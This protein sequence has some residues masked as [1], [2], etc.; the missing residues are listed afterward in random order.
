MSLVL[1]DWLSPPTHAEFNQNLY[2]SLECDFTL[3]VYHEDLANSN[4]ECIIQS[5]P[6]SRL[7]HALEVLKICWKHRN[8]KI[9]FITYDD[10]YAWI[11]QFFVKT[12][13]SFEHKTTPDR[14]LL[15]K[16]ALWQRLLFYKIQRLC[17]SKAQEEVLKK[18]GQRS[19]WLGLP[20]SETDI[21][22]KEEHAGSFLMVSEL[23]NIDLAKVV[24]NI[25]YGEVKIKKSVRNLKNLSL[26][27]VSMIKKVDRFEFPED[28]LTTE[29]FVLLTDSPVRG[30][31]WFVEAIKFG[32]PLVLVT[33][34]QQNVFEGTF[35]GYPYIKGNKIANQSELKSEIAK[36]RDFNTSKYV[37]L[38]MNE[39]K[40]RLVDILKINEKTCS[41]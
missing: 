5:R 6:S 4:I 8:K 7:S 32:I 40:K 38:Y 14:S 19:D 16:H 34:E 41:T 20:I 2:K 3:Y 12:I 10:L 9:L 28:L 21:Q 39:F 18:M 11:P 36:I 22:K 1:I 23:I 25:L 26:K 37:N 30:S 35:P 17:Q 15:D 31:G 33:S 13:F 29:A 24:S 27:G